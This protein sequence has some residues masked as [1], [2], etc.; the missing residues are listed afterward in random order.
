MRFQKGNTPWNKG[1]TGKQVAWNKGLTNRPAYHIIPHSEIAKAKCSAS[2]KARWANGAYSNRKSKIVLKKKSPEER[3]WLSFNCNYCGKQTYR[4][5]GN[6]KGKY[7]YCS[8]ICM[9]KSKSGKNHINWQGG[10]SR[11]SDIL[12]NSK[13]WRDW[14]KS[15]FERDNYT[16]IMCGNYGCRLEPHHIK[17]KSK[18]IEL[19][20]NINNGAT[21]CYKCHQKTKG[22][23]HSFES[24]LFGLVG[25]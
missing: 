7:I 18:F 25:G 20:F 17:P 23:E 22:K 19:V 12:R 10:K 14:R 24:M 2:Q 15:V 8:R 1:L 4:Y 13:E 9:G 16:C 5:K 11:I 21:L 6:A 3:K